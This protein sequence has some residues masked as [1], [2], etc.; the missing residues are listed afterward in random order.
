MKEE[1]KLHVENR[2]RG[3]M[4]TKLTVSTEDGGD[5]L[6]KRQLNMQLNNVII[7]Y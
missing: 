5:L 7:I 1:V 6:Q 3:S 2:K 4:D